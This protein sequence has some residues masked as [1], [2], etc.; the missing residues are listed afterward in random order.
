MYTREAAACASVN[1]ETIE[2][3]APVVPHSE[4]DNDRPYTPS[5]YDHDRIGAWATAVAPTSPSISSILFAPGLWKDCNLSEPSQSSLMSPSAPAKEKLTVANP[6]IVSPQH[7]DYSE[8]SSSSFLTE[9]PAERWAVV[10]YRDP[11]LKSRNSSPRSSDPPLD[12]ATPPNCRPV[13]EAPHWT[14]NSEIMI[15]INLS[16]DFIGPLMINIPVSSIHPAHHL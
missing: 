14:F 11:V 3:V 7:L 8:S 13:R 16:A 4:P 15:N 1:P 6:P 12:S 2:V 10:L 5:F 9:N